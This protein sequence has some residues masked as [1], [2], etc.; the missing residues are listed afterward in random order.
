MKKNLYQKIGDIQEKL[1]YLVKTELNKFQGYKYFNEKNILLKLNPLLKNENIVLLFSDLVDNFICEK[2]E[3]EWVV[4]YVKKIEVIN[5]DDINER[6][7]INF[8][9]CGQ[10]T[11]ISKAKGSAETYAMKYFLQKFFLIP[12]SD[13]LDPD[14][15][16]K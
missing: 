4:R 11:D 8:W 5:C 2:I 12:T 7:K 9:A 14:I 16:S 1:N 3:K 6:L 13:N 10:N 15:F